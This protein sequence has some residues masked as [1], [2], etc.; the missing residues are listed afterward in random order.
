MSGQPNS[1]PALDS[2]DNRL[3]AYR[4]DLADK[5][6]REKIKADNYVSGKVARVSVPVADLKGSP[7]TKANTEHQLLLGEEVLVF[8]TTNGWAWIQAIRDGYV[9]Y[10]ETSDIEDF[11]EAATHIVKAPSTFIYPKAELRS[12]VTAHLSMG[13]SLTIVGTQTVRGTDY[14][15]L[16]DGTAVI[17]KHLRKIGNHDQDF[18]S[19]CEQFAH[20]PYLWGGSSGFGFDCSGL[21][22]LAMRMCGREVLRDSDMQAA[23]LGEV[24]EPGKNLENLQRGDLIFWRGHIAIYKGTM[25][26]I[27]HIIH[28]S[29]HTMSVDIEPLHEAIERIAYLY[30]KPIGFRRP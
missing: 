3:N 27:P 28:A 25:H 10:L 9:G 16:S 13:S 6:L 18:V 20:T 4:P 12:P 22:Q 5:R 29:G 1:L 19:I 23:T 24:I 30:E 2:L 15:I 7:A 14:S 26:N 17:A 11:K 21:V 8:E